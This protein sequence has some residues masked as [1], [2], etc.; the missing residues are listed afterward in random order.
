VNALNRP[1]S[2]RKPRE[3]GADFTDL[4][5]AREAMLGGSEA[6]RRE[7]E[8]QLAE[9]KRQLKAVFEHELVKLDDAGVTQAEISRKLG[10]STVT[11][12]KWYRDLG[13]IARET[14]ARRK[15]AQRTV[16]GLRFAWATTD[17]ER[18]QV[19]VTFERDITYAGIEVY[20]GSE[21]VLWAREVD[22]SGTPAFPLGKDIENIRFIWHRNEDIRMI[23]SLGDRF[24]RD[25]FCAWFTVG[26]GNSSDSPKG[27]P[28]KNL[29]LRD[30]WRHWAQQEGFPVTRAGMIAA[31]GGDEPEPEPEDDYSD[32][33][34]ALIEAEE[35]EREAR[36]DALRG[37]LPG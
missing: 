1:A 24:R 7:L 34:R 35:A 33:D 6:F 37:R 14:L 22:P 27:A 31:R 10:V 4:I 30:A 3:S 9:H 11:V 15:S 8:Q 19:R 25:A 17:P 36:K 21:A 13:G 12:W 18:I 23:T 20:A 32:E 29:E 2:T 5:Q 26:A 28:Q 16:P